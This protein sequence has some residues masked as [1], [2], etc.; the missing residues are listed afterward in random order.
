MFQL[1]SDPELFLE[2][3]TGKVISAIGKIGGHKDKPKKVPKLG[4]GF[5]I[6]EDNVLLEFNTPPAKLI[7]DWTANHVKMMDYLA[8]LVGKMGLKLSNKAS[9]SMDDDQLK[10]PKAFVFGC[11]PD[12]SVWNLEW[13]S[14]PACDDPNLRSAGGHIHVAYD[15]PTPEKSIRL[16]RLLDMTV[17]APLAKV[18]PDKRRAKLYGRPGAIRFKPYGLEY[19]TPSNYW[20]LNPT[21]MDMVF[22]AV[23]MT[24]NGLL[25]HYEMYAPT[26][27]K[28]RDFLAGEADYPDLS[29]LEDFGAIKYV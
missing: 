13:N 24:K 27:E 17:G 10:H 6:Q 11:E 20:L 29:L 3:E 19:R 7:T 5:A 9:H 15:N 25:P 16:A 8:A 12:F 2:D 22:K 4:A 28:C 21:N 14:K 1:G 23:V 26:A 18:D